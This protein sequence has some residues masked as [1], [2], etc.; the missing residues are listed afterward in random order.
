MRTG[1]RPQA[2]C[3]FDR[4]RNTGA[5]PDAVIGAGDIVVHRFRDRNGFDAFLVHAH[6]IAERIVATDRDEIID[7]KE[8]KV[9][10]HIWCDIIDIFRV[11]VLQ[12]FRKG[13]LLYLGWIRAGRVQEGAPGATGSINDF[14]GQH[15]VIVAVI[16]FFITNDIYQP[17]PAATNANNFVPFSRGAD[18][19]SANGRVQARNVAASCQNPDDTLCLLYHSST[20]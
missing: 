4:A 8:I 20:P 11:F 17:A 5:E 18:G 19:Y 3:Q 1:Y 15:P 14:F 6:A 16:C 12:V 13:I 7:P 2:V 9:L 10:K